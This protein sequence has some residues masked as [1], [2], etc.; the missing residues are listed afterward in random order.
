[1]LTITL[2]DEQLDLIV[3]LLKNAI[4]SE[5]E[6]AKRP[7]MF[8]DESADSW[9]CVASMSSVMAAFSEAKETSNAIS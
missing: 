5:Y 6:R 9:R 1:M 8:R 2:T 3:V 7:G 4:N